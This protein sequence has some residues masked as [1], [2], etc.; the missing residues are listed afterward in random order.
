MAIDSMQRQYQRTIIPLYDYES[1]KTSEERGPSPAKQRKLWMSVKR[2]LLNLRPLCAMINTIK[3]GS[4][5]T[6]FSCS[7]RKGKGEKL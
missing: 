2:N 4:G 6:G 7:M 3:K 5:W 1:N